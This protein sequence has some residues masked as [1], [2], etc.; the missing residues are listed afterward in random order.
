LDLFFRELGDAGRP[1][2]I[3]HGLFG[4]SDN[5]LTLA[6]TFAIKHKVYLPDLRN[7][8]QSPHS[9]VFNY[10]AMADDLAHLLAKQNITKPLLIGHSMG[11]KVLMNFANRYP[12]IAQ[13]L[14]IVD[15]A[16]RYYPVHHHQVLQGLHAVNLPAIGS[17]TEA[18]EVLRKHEDNEAVVQFLLKNLWRNPASNQF[19]WR[20]NL[21]VLT[22]EIAQ[23][24]DEQYPAKPIDTPTLY[25]RG[26]NSSYITDADQADIAQHYSQVQF[27]TIPDAGHWVQAER[28]AEFLDIVNDFLQKNNA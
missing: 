20:I 25:L 14:I 24:G 11:G 21:P 15:I 26:G 18:A 8:G 16:P 17:R 12:S 27:A 9:E 4:M 5:W 23:I 10:D 2:I 7:H 1:L 3:L 6:K 19:D 13:A 28:P 22:K